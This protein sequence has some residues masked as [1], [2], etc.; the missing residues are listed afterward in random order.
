MN[1]W[2][3]IKF[4]FEDDLVHTFHLWEVTL[5]L[6]TTNGYRRHPRTIANEHEFFSFVNVYIYD[7]R[8]DKIVFAIGTRGG[9]LEMDNQVFGYFT[10]KLQCMYIAVMHYNI[11]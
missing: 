4:Y 2:S 5:W 11:S 7:G 3:S 8:Y 10:S 9:L 1:Q 6:S